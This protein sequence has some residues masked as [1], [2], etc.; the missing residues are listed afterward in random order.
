MEDNH[1]LIRPLLHPSTTN[2][3]VTPPLDDHVHHNLMNPIS[4]NSGIIFRLSLVA[5]IGIV[6]IWANHEASKG[7]SVTIV[8]DS[9]QT[10]VAG[11]RFHLFYVSNDE[12]TRVVVKASKIIENFLY[13]NHDKIIP[14]RK[15]VKHIVLKLSDRNLTDNYAV[16][17][18]TNLE[19]VL[20]ISPS[21]MGGANFRHDTVLAMQRGVAR[22]WLWDGLTNL[23]NGIV[24]Y[25]VI[26]NLGGSSA[27]S[28]RADRAEP[29][30]SATACWKNDD[31]RVVA[32][33]LNNCEHRRPGFIRRLNQAMKN[34]WD[35]GK[36]DGALG[37]PV[38]NL[39]ASNNE[40]LRYNF[41]S[42]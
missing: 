6:S 26:N 40:S 30:Q 32:E 10:T 7:Y 34:G 38:Q 15:Q 37:Q 24:E 12:A 13:P 20:T 18:N 4:S 42:V 8:N 27:A 5:F 29:P 28:S 3:A 21:I 39:C 36:L 2:A 25:M 41:S 22:I 17:S 9:G 14:S 33:F 35:D 31:S 11:K 23:I 1:H 19:F 16:Y